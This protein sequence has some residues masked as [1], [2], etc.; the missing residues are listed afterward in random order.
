VLL[1]SPT[2]NA[3][4]EAHDV[5]IL[6]IVMEV[7]GGAASQLAADRGATRWC[8]GGRLAAHMAFPVGDATTLSLSIARRVHTEALSHPRDRTI[9]P[10]GLRRTCPSA[11]SRRSDRRP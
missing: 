10:G 4:H 5:S 7:A 3:Y 9:T 11:R 8:H 2:C 6:T 1:D